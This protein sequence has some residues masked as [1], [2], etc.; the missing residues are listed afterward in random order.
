[1]DRLR[2]IVPLTLMSWTTSRRELEKKQR[3]LRK[4]KPRKLKMDF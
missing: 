2:Y 3:K 1:M 4:K